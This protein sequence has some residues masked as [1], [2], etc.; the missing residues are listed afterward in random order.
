MRCVPVATSSTATC[1]FAGTMRTSSVKVAI[2]VPSGLNEGWACDRPRSVSVRR[3][4]VRDPGRGG[5]TGSCNFFQGKG[6]WRSW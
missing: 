2:C 3:S 1:P 5:G 4:P 6:L